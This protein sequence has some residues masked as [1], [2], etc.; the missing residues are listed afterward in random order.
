[1][2]YD[3]FSGLKTIHNNVPV[4]ARMKKYYFTKKRMLKVLKGDSTSIDEISRFPVP[5][6]SGKTSLKST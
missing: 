2:A 6:D 5:R 1:M 4:F 3:V